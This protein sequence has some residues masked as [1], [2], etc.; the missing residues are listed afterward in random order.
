MVAPLVPPEL[1][2]EGVVLAKPTASPD[3]AL[4]LTITGDW[5]KVLAARAQKVRV[6][7]AG[8]P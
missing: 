6:W 8:I 1:H 2:T 5:A 3:E 7:Q 4:A